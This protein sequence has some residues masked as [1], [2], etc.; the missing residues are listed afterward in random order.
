[1]KRVALSLLSIVIASLCTACA[2]TTS[3]NVDS[4]PPAVESRPP[5]SAPTNDPSSVLSRPPSSV[6]THTERPERETLAFGKSYRWKDG[7]SL[8]VG[9]PK[10]FTPSEFAV[11]KKTK[12]YLRF[13]VT[14]VN[15][16]KKPIDLGL[17]YISVKSRNKEAEH[18]FDSPTGL[19]G[20]PDRK[21]VKGKKSE[22]DVGFGVADPNDLVME[23]A[24]HQD[25]FTRPSAIY[26][27]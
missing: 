18:V 5:S 24:L 7:V 16:S 1:V 27:T 14:V 10:K 12:R 22:F 26:S 11:T 4:N 17:T 15:R 21:I 6:P 3:G 25:G 9:K 23:L 13:T 2:A 19:N 8:T 20:P